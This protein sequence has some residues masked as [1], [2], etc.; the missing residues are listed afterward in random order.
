MR[1]LPR[2]LP[3]TPTVGGG[4][5]F[6]QV[7]TAPPG[8]QYVFEHLLFD[9]VIYPA[10]GAAGLTL[11]AFGSNNRGAD[12]TMSNWP[13]NGAFG[14]RHRFHGLRL[15]CTPLTEPVISGAADAAGRV[16]DW[17]RI[18]KIG[19]AVL[20]FDIATTGRRRMPIPLTALPSL[21][22]PRATIV[23]A[24]AF[25]VQHVGQIGNGEGYP[26]DL[27]LGGGEAFTLTLRMRPD[28]AQAISA[29]LPIQFA[30]YGWMYQ[31][32]G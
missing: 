23:G 4:P 21:N 2:P 8:G 10:A 28:V 16:R 31:P 17:D 18:T 12:T 20:D 22:G 13:V 30:L 5:T 1:Q 24:P 9:T 14:D 15:F 11:S 3:L 6:D 26:F 27:P 29:D 32:A 25:P 19:R 7:R